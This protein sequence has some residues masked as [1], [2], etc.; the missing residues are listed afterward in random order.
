MSRNAKPRKAY[1]P[2]PVTRHTLAVAIDGAAKPAADDRAQVIAPV[3]QAIRAL[4]EG[5][6]T[7][8]Q[9]SIA[10][11]ALSVAMAIER[12]GVVRGLLGHLQAAGTAL[13]AIYDRAIRTGGGRWVRVTL[14]GSEIE[15]LQLL[16][17]LHT[18]QINQLGRAE[19]LAVIAAAEKDVLA[20]GHTAFVVTDLT[21]IERIAA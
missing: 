21:Q 5:V 11:G 19:F 20:Q 12:Q 15:D 1:R 3:A 17:E 9:W 10:S 13:Q 2:R 14:Y 6:A 16:L 7:Q 4:R 8:M 18:Y